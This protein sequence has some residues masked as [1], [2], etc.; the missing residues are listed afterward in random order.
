M[1]GG[2]E[3]QQTADIAWQTLLV[4]WVLVAG[5]RGVRLPPALWDALVM[6]TL[7]PRSSSIFY[8]RAQE[9][10]AEAVTRTLGMYAYGVDL[11]DLPLERLSEQKAKKLAG[12]QEHQR[13]GRETRAMSLDV[14]KEALALQH[15]EQQKIANPGTHCGMLVDTVA[16]AILQRTTSARR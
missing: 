15:L 11:Y 16:S 14:R 10:M 8:V 13:V 2:H 3:A 4:C 1:H 12:Q 7:R 5:V 6:D 9:P